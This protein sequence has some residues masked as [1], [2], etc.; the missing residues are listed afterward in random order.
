MFCVLIHNV[1][2]REHFYNILLFSD[3]DNLSILKVLWPLSLLL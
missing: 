3:L 1:V 2:Q